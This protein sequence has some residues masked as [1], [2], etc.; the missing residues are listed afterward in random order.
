MTRS[1]LIALCKER[2]IKGYSKLTKTELVEKLSGTVAEVK[3]VAK[4]TAKTDISEEDANAAASE[5]A[6]SEESITKRWLRNAILDQKQHR[7]IGKFLAPVCE[8][9]VIARLSEMTGRTIKQVVGESYDAITDDDKPPVKIQI[10]FRM[11]AWHLETTRRNSQKNAETNGTGHIAYKDDEFDLL[12]IFK[13]SGTFGITGS[14]IR[15]IPV[16]EIRNPA[17]PGQLVTQINGPLRR[18][19]DSDEKTAEVIRDY[20]QTPA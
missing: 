8:E 11:G 7:D 17:K 18:S 3:T 14:T 2:N 9:Y 6:G 5:W 13:P 1:E 10:K 20:L 12:A 15:C 16:S 4:K 19:Y